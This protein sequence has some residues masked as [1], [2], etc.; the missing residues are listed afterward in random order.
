MGRHSG[1][2]RCHR[3]RH[4]P[5]GPRIVFAADGSGRVC[6]YGSQV[7][8]AFPAGGLIAGVG[9]SAGA[10]CRC[11]WRSRSQSVSTGSSSSGWETTSSSRVIPLHS[12]RRSRA[13]KNQRTFGLGSSAGWPRPQAT[14]RRL[15]QP[16]SV[17]APADHR[18]R[19]LEAVVPNPGRAGRS[20]HGR[21]RRPAHGG[22][23]IGVVGH[24][25]R[26]RPLRDSVGLR[27][28]TRPSNSS[29]SIDSTVVGDN[30]R[31]RLHHAKEDRHLMARFGNRP[32]A[33]L[34]RGRSGW[35]VY[36]LHLHSERAEFLAAYVL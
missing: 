15:S 14:T 25:R 23:A 31:G 11:V 20:G 2:L 24:A 3:P 26:N 1:R 4:R 27:R 30:L 21:T 7:G 17:A 10:N 5:S 9:F 29:A 19:P 13:V 6:R 16:S 34:F 33:V 18:G 12:W 8:R 36:V 32:P 22:V 35:V 28:L